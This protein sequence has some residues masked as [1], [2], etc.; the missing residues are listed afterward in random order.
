MRPASLSLPLSSTGPLRRF[1]AKVLCQPASIID[2][3]DDR[4]E[5]GMTLPMGPLAGPE[6]PG[7]GRELPKPLFWLLVLLLLM[8]LVLLVLL[9]DELGLL[10]L[11]EL[12]G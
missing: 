12:L 2:R 10:V 7:M 4:V 9:R 1:P 6:R 11:R 3:E 8:D 5:E